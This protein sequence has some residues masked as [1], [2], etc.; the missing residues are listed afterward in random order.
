MVFLVLSIWIFVGQAWLGELVQ[1]A[2]AHINAD[3][4]ADYPGDGPRGTTDHDPVL[5]AYNLMPSID[6]LVELLY[7]FEMRGDITGIN[8]FKNLLQHLEK[9]Q[10]F[11]DQ[12]QMQACASQ[13][14]TFSLQAQGYAPQYVTQDAADALSGEAWMILDNELSAYLLIDGLPPQNNQIFIPLIV[15]NNP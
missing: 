5:E 9:A 1:T 2:A 13:I 4:P 12:D 6:R 3:F 7:Y 15:T 14:K 8:T 10:R 11:C